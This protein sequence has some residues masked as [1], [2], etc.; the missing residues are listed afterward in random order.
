[1]ATLIQLKKEVIIKKLEYVVVTVG[2][3]VGTGLVKMT[4]ELIMKDLK[5]LLLMSQQ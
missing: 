3:S 1:M 4:I 5:R 2:D